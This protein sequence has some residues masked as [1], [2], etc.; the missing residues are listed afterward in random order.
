MNAITKPRLVKG[1][2]RIYIGPRIPYLSLE[3]EGWFHGFFQELEECDTGGA[4]GGPV[5]LVE[6]RCMIDKQVAV[7]AHRAE[8]VK[9]KADW[10][11]TTDYT[12]V[13][14]FNPAV[15]QIL[16]IYPKY[17]RFISEE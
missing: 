4:I 11:E 3:I 17:L 13:R 10:I 16:E 2:Y 15:G 7:D 1:F 9:N 12:A 14:D 5:A 6:F 8:G